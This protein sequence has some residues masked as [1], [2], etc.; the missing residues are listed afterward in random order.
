MLQ[1]AFQAF[2]S[3]RLAEAEALSRKLLDTAPT[4]EGARLLLAMSLDAQSRTFEAIAEF[5][6]LVEL[7]PQV[8][9]HWTN[10]GNARSAM[11]Y[12]S[13][14]RDALE[15]AIRLDPQNSA[16]LSGL[17]EISLGTGAFQAARD[18]L[19]RAQT[20]APEDGSLRSAAARACYECGDADNAEALLEGWRQWAAADALTLTDVAW[21]FARIG[22]IAQAE[23]ALEMA[24]ILA[25]DHP[26]VLAR[27]AA[28]YERSNRL[29]E[30]RSLLKRIDDGA[31]AA[32]GLGEEVAVIRATL[33]GRGEDLEEACRL[34]EAVLSNPG[35]QRRNAYLHFSL[36]RLY[37][38][39]GNA[40]AAMSWLE[41][42]HT[43]QVRQLEAYVPELLEADADLLETERLRLTAADRSRWPASWSSGEGATPIF[44]LGFPRSG[45]T[46]LET[47]LDAHPA[48]AG[49]DERSFLQD[50]IKAMAGLG[51]SYPV[52]L[53]RLDDEACR[54]L[55]ET[56]WHLVHTRARID[57]AQ[58]LV[59]KN[60]LNMFRL[61]LI[62]RL[63]PDAKII[64]ALR[65]PCD[66]VL[67]NYM[68]MFHAPAYA[69]M[70]AT[71]ES[72]ARGYAK[73][74]EFW[75][76]QAALLRPQVLELQYE[77]IVAGIEEQSRRVTDFL[78]VGWDE[79]MVRFHDHARERGFIAT[80]SYHQVVEPM[81]RRGIG[82]WERY[83]RFLEP[84][85]PHLKPYLDRWN[86]AA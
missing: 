83:R 9:E 28:L 25:P 16:A 5:E 49:M 85:L 24:Q 39:C 45:T 57:P 26:R 86:Y 48:L 70:C 72:T 59:D 78:G 82:R 19:L 12:H 32:R 47:I 81:N 75:I 27:R 15:Q 62:A 23:S 30:A 56:Y 35:A 37:D 54:S 80:P 33:A 41:R 84:A 22:D 34:H 46:M 74:F 63:F 21:I 55:R 36:A 43:L 40:D 61:P 8:S 53:G 64:L 58:R 79:R 10:L 42:G 31:A 69:A 1:F 44:V 2:Q 50:V 73:A 52:D 6:Q 4:H 11:G 76:D 51:L 18:Y 68:Q 67:S 71:L 7:S 14:A 38:R 65:H 13:G 60:P 77:D 3:G 29:D 20:L 17:G 66:V